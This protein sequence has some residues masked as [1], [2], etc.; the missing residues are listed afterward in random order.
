MAYINYD[1]YT[2][3]FGGTLIPESEF[4]RIAEIA[5]MI[6]DAASYCPIDEEADYF[7]KVKKAVAYEADAIY[8]Y[9]GYDAA[10]G[11]S[12]AAISSESLD[13]YSYSLGNADKS[14]SIQMYNGIPVSP[15]TLS[16]LSNAGLRQRWVYAY[17]SGDEDEP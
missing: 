9:G 1:Y 13:E 6:V 8:S 4:P 11:L 2:G 16:I 10:I 14:R 7:H 3:Q 5:S 17:E 15:L 12:D